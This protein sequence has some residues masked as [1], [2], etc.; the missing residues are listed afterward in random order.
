MRNITLTISQKYVPGWGLWEA[1]REF[2]Q[3]ALDEAIASVRQEMQILRSSSGVNVAEAL[4]K[5]EE[6]SNGNCEVAKSALGDLADLKRWR[7]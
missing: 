4:G 3:N 1:L 5:L 7:A 6:A 2:T